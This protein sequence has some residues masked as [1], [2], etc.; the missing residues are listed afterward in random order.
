MFKSTAT[1]QAHVLLRVMNISSSQGQVCGNL[2]TSCPLS[3]C[4]MIRCYAPP[5]HDHHRTLPAFSF[6]AQTALWYA[7]HDLEDHTIIWRETDTLLS[8]QS[9]PPP[10]NAIFVS[11]NSYPPQAPSVSPCMTWKM[12]MCSLQAGLLPSI[13]PSPP[14]YLRR[15]PSGNPC[16]TWKMALCSLSAGRMLTPYSAARGSTKGPPAISVSLL[17]RQMSFLAL[18]AATVGSRRDGG[19]GGT[20]MKTWNWCVGA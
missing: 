10:G 19:G 6:T 20:V 12:A 14:P 11:V 3:D 8:A 17:A 13:L 7:Q 18:M 1:Q 15:P 9:A 16:M 4:R 5:S 2:R